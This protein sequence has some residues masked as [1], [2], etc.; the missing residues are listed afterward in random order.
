MRVQWN[1][2]DPIATWLALGEQNRWIPRACDPPFTR[3]SFVACADA[4]E[5]K[6]WLAHGN[7]CVGSAFFL[8]D[9]ASSSGRRALASGLSSSRTLHSRVLRAA[10]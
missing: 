5:L 3:R 7:W 9:L 4:E 2:A 8:C 6:R 10:T 1:P